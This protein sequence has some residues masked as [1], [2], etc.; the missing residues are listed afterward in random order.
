MTT[1]HE[2][3]SERIVGESGAPKRV[4]AAPLLDV[5]K[6]S[7]TYRLGGGLFA[8]GRAV[9][10]VVD[11]SFTV[12]RAETVAVVGESGCGKSTLARA[13]AKLLPADRG[14][15]GVRFDGV[16]LLPLEGKALLPFRR[17]LQLVFQDPFTSLNPRLTVGTA[18]AEPVRRHRSSGDRSVTDHVRELVAMVGLPADAIHR[19]PHE[20]SGGQRQR[21]GIARA[22]SVGP[23]LVIC[24]EPL[25]A[26]DLSIQAQVVNLLIDLQERLGLSYL[27][28][29]HDLR[30]VRR[31]S[32]RV[33]VMYLGEIVEEGPTE[34]VYTRPAH[35]YTR[36]LLAAVPR[37]ASAKGRLPEVLGGEPPNPAQRPQGCAFAARCPLVE[38]RCRESAPSLR[39]A[40]H[41]GRAACWVTTA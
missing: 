4:A 34:A 24:D 5:E 11:V 25:S 2:S 27:F 17:R 40:S 23:E 31:L 7:V 30:V 18:L 13:V 12:G 19:Y 9:P 22:L 6:L 20:F 1:E 3:P 41:G 37:G 21:V 14:S 29:S 26:L 36:A 39:S 33:L 15:R 8:K 38:A 10:A 16:D 28:I 35:P 32:H